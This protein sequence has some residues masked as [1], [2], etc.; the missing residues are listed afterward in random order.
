MV[1]PN[2][3]EKRAGI[4]CKCGSRNTVWICSGGYQE[5]KPEYGW[6]QMETDGEVWCK[7]CN[8]TWWE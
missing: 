1:K 7:D 8:R 4:K 2:D 6:P 5:A 3:Q